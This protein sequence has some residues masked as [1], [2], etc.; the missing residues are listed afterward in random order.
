MATSPNSPA[1][2]QL[3]AT[4]ALKAIHTA[5]AMRYLGLLATGPSAEL[6][7][8]AAQGISFFVNGIGIPTSASSASMAWLGSG[9]PSGY[10]TPDTKQHLGYRIGQG[11]SAYIA[12][13][14]SWWQQHPEIH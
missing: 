1:K 9:Q 5:A 12:Y 8:P 3:A 11:E 2:L 10:A 14:Q 7:L 6:Q 13:W 4:Q